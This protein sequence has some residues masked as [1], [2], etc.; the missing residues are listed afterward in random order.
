M[1]SCSVP[2]C[3]QCPV[4]QRLPLGLFVVENGEITYSNPALHEIIGEVLVPLSRATL[5]QIF[6]PADRDKVESWIQAPHALTEDGTYLDLCLKVPADSKLSS[7]TRLFAHRINNHST[8]LV[9]VDRKERPKRIGWATE[10]RLRF[11]ELLTDL[12]SRFINQPTQDVPAL[13]DDSIRVLVEFLG[14]DRTTLISFD[15]DLEYVTVM[16]SYSVM[17]CEPFPLGRLPVNRLPWFIGTMQAGK[18]V[19]VRDIA[20]DLPTEAEKEREYCVA[21]GIRSNVSLPLRAGGNVLGGLTFAFL[22]QTCDWPGDVLERLQLIANVFASML[23]RQRAE[24]N[25]RES[26]AENQ[27]LRRLMEQENSYLREQVS[28]KHQHDR[29]VG[30]GDAITRVLAAAERVAVTDAPVLLLGETGTGKEL[31]SQTIHD[32]S[33]RKS[34]AMI[35]LN[36]ASLPAT[37]IESELF[38]REA[39]AY[40]GAASA[41]VGHFQLADGST[42]FLDEVGELPIELQA[43]LLRVLEDGTFHRLGDPKT[44]HVDVR[45]IAATNRDLK[46]AIR[47]GRFR[48]D[49]YH[50]LNVFPIH[51]PPLRERREDIPLLAWA[52]AEKLGR[53]MGKSIKRISRKTMNQLQSYSWPG[54][55]RELSNAIER[56]I[57]LTNDDSLHVTLPE[58]LAT[59][60]EKQPTLE[61]IQHEQILRVLNQTGWRI[62]GPRGAA[63][64]LEIKPTTLEARMAKLGIKRPGGDELTRRS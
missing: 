29:I 57:I 48:E 27:R 33:K 45:I 14:N 41:Q 2:Q 51:M 3:D 46:Q 64:L 28:L 18:T 39:G 1:D 34:R 24:E 25:L 15:E 12:S 54:N 42:L 19:F 36:C 30:Q 35:V 49:L 59:S 43:K 32:L 37:L 61:E 4:L 21:H 22:R 9:M 26:L 13:I 47:E 6:H 50:R 58:T 44:I 31:L 38:G 62:R 63:E 60:Q 52:F 8:M 11:E 5:M 53:R 10:Q 7:K 16:N 20:T 17:G 40:T 23:M 55:V 56:A